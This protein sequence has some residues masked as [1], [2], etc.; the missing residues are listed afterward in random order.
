MAGKEIKGFKTGKCQEHAQGN[1]NQSKTKKEAKRRVNSHPRSRGMSKT[2]RGGSN[3]MGC[4]KSII[5]PKEGRKKGIANELDL[6]G[7]SN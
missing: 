1:G 5:L 4:I 6:P 7:K 2:T 3:S